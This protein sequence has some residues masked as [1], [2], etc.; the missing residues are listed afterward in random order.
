MWTH[1]ETY[2]G[3]DF[4]KMIHKSRLKKLLNISST[5]KLNEIGKWADFGCSDGFILEYI[6]RQTVPGG[7]ELY[8]FDHSNDLLSKARNKNISNST[9][10]VFD[11]NKVENSFHCRFDV[12]SCF[13][14]LEHT[15]SYKN[16]FENIYLSAKVGGFILLSVPNET[17]FVGCM[18]F[19]GRKLLRRNEYASFFSQPNSSEI[20]YFITLLTDKDIE[21]FRD[22]DADNWGQ[23]LGFNYRNLERYMLIEYV[24]ER[25]LEIIKKTSSFFG[26]NKIYVL[27]KL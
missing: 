13:E 7:W 9:F 16:A 11:L 20:K 27:R 4:Y 19:I 24:K 18:K 23:H 12:V 21:A 8:G 10:V 17:G 1:A 3:S 25:K 22:R 26:C 5:L 6:R 14:T 15:G 2:K